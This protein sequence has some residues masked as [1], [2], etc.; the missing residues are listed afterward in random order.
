MRSGPVG[1]VALT[2]VLAL[3][4]CGGD[5]DGASP[6]PT[7]TV[8]RTVTVAPTEPTEAPTAVPTEPRTPAPTDTGTGAEALPEPCRQTGPDSPPA[9]LAFI[10]VLSPSPG[11]SVSGPFEVTGCAST[12]EANVVYRVVDADGAVLDEGNTTASC[13]TGCVGEFSFTASADVSERQVVFLE[14][15]DTS[16][17][18][19]S[20]TDLNRIPLIAG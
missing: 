1:I 16:P 2:L 18:D 15:F 8:T 19:G 14:V 13:G 9:D 11:T 5:D 12:F 4:A 7:V 20:V 10:F 6:A 17:R 3:G